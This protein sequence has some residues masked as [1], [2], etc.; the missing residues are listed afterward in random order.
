MVLYNIISCSGFDTADSYLASGGCMKA[1]F[2]IVILF[3]LIAVIRKWGGEEMGLDFNFFFA[4]IG[5]LL[6]YLIPIIVSGN[7]KFAFVIGLV[8]ALAGGYVLGMFFE[9]GGE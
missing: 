4:I 5:G 2:G 6:G 7:F 1:R 9:G 8:A 3:F